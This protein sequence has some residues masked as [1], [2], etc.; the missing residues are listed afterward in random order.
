MNRLVCSSTDAIDEHSL[1]GRVRRPG[2]PARVLFLHGMEV[3]FSTTTGNLEHY[4]ARRA[5]IDA[6]HVRLAMPG[7][8]RLACRQFPVPIG[9]LDYRYLRHMLFWRMHLRGLVGPGRTL[10]LDRFDVVH[11]TTQQRGLIVEDFRGPGA[12]PTGT[13]FAINLD[14]TLRGWERM[15]GLRRLAP[16]IDW[17]MEGR[18]LRSADLL[19]CA[20]AWA[21]DSCVEE[22]GVE[23]GRVVIHKPCA[24]VEGHDSARPAEAHPRF[25]MIFVGGDW[26]DKGGARLLRWHQ[27]RWAERAELHVVS[28]SAPAGGRLRNVVFH[29]RV[30]HEKLVGELLPSMD[31]FVVPTM[32]DTFM[33]AAQEAQQ[34]GLPVVTTRTGGVGACVEHGVTGF[35]CGRENEGEYIA[36]VERLMDDGDLRA[37]MGRAA[38]EHAERN[39]SAEVWHNH[40]LDQ[41]VALADGRALRKVPTQSDRVAQ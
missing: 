11:I 2:E 20:T 35:L 34:A 27:E 31:L 37:R 4:A 8:L 14:A 25:R 30:A 19:A 1:P 9:E 3:G 22:Y 32:W 7:W 17:R 5:D 13:R 24:R 16:A 12:N 18:I 38:R 10:P 26:R 28:E 39:L 6:V 23:P 29:G 15:R 40:L 41:L 33:I 21:G 36:A